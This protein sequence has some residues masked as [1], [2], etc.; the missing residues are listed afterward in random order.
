MSTA[1]TCTG[2]LYVPCPRCDGDRHVFA[3]TQPPTEYYR[4]VGEYFSC[5]VCGGTGEAEA[6]K[7]A[8]WVK[9]HQ[10]GE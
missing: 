9:E 1:I 3:Y 6:E 8:E 7:A 4:G 10:D 2:D 5:P